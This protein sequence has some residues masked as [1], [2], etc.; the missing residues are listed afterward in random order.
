MSVS[1]SLFPMICLAALLSSAHASPQ[2][3][4]LVSKPPDPDFFEGF[5]NADS[6]G[7]EFSEDGQR[8]VFY[9]SAFNLV[10]DDDNPDFDVFVFDRST[11]TM[12]LISRTAKG[13]PARGVNIPADISGNGRFVLMRSNAAGLGSEAIQQGYRHDMDTSLKVPVGFAPDGSEFSSTEP[14]ALTSDGRYV[15]FTADSQAWLRDLDEGTTTL[16]SIGIDDQPA[17]ESAFTARVSADGST[18][19]FRS[20]ASNL[21]A[22]D[23]N[24]ERDLFIRDLTLGTTAR[25][26]GLGGLD[27]DRAS[28]SAR[29]SADGRWVAFASSATNLVSGDSNEVDD[30]FLH[31]RLNDVTIRLS[32]DSNGVGGNAVS[33]NVAISGDGRFM[34]FESEADNLVPGLTGLENRLYLYDRNFDTLVQVAQ[35]TDF[36]FQPCIQNNGSE[37]WIAYGATA[38]PLIPE[39]LQHRQIVLESFE[40]SDPDRG[41]SA[42]ASAR[43][44]DRGSEQAL[45]ISRTDPPLP[46]EVGNGD[47]LQPDV[48]G[49]GRFV[50]FRTSA[51]NL[52]GESPGGTQIVRLDRLTGDLEIVS[53]GAGGEPVATPWPPAMPST[54]ASGNRVAFLTRDSNLVAGDTNDL[55]DIFVRD[56]ELGQIA[57]ISIGNNDEEAN[58]RSDNPVISANGG[59]VAF[60]S[61]ASNLVADDT[62]GYRDI[63]VRDFDSPFLER[64]SISTEN[65]EFDAHSE[66]PDINTTGRF[67]VFSSSGGLKDGPDLFANE[68]IWLRDRQAGTTELI[69]ATADGEPGNGSSDWPKISANGR[70]IAFRSTASNLDPEFPD[71]QGSSIYLHDRQTGAS[72]LVSLDR[73]GQPVPVLTGNLV[74]GPMLA[75]DGSA[76]MFQRFITPDETDGLSG[77]PGS[78]PEGTI[79]LFDRLNQQTTI[80]EPVTTDGLPPGEQLLPAAV[81][82]GGRVIYLVSTARNL[83]PGMVTRHSDIYRIDLDFD[84]LFKDRF[85]ARGVSE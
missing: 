26:D 58:G 76:L 4:Q 61:E 71:V 13:D 8:L 48:A 30:V 57:R 14:W 12:E 64:V 75:P 51:G 25:I 81:E 36:P 53:L 3:A 33:R 19:V 6:Q 34:I 27:P 80:I 20:A 32:E 23:E 70:W 60:Q 78:D 67:V 1:E 85:Q 21:V 50:V 49:S 2:L 63:F 79:Y 77:L 16:I 41:A 17:N 56:L 42:S 5:G 15:S 74:R 35:F 84:R 65:L 82:P 55:E 38:H 28:G 24:E 66:S 83:I 43:P 59:T 62:N 11:G 31:D 45:I 18:V 37:G 22:D 29:L 52:I 54:D 69:S 46:V 47:S 9:S 73:E 68:Q 40:S 7:C 10:E 39:R 72:K 44:M